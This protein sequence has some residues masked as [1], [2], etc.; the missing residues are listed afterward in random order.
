M[1]SFNLLAISIRF[2]LPWLL[3]LIIPLVGLMLWPYFRLPKQ[4]RRT[5][6]RVISL[7]I[8]SLILVL[9]VC[10]VSG[11]SLHSTE[12]VAKNDV[13]LLVDLS[14]S[15]K[16]SKE[17]MDEFIRT[18]LNKRENNYRVGIVTFANGS[19]YASQIRADSDR[20]YT[21]YLHN[22]DV[23]LGNATNI[24]EALLFAKSALSNP[25]N[26]RIIILSD[27]V[28]TDGNALAVV[29]S[30]ADGGTRVDAA[31]FSFEGRASE[32]LI[33]SVDVPQR[34]S[35]GDTLQ[36][37]VRV[38]SGSAREAK[39]KLFDN[40]ECVSE[41][42][43]QLSGGEDQ[44]VFEYSLLTPNL[45]EFRVEIAAQGDVLEENN[46]YYAYVNIETYTN[47]LVVDGTGNESALISELLDDTYDITTT[48]PAD[49]PMTITELSI[50]GEVIFMNVAN[51][52]LP[53]G[54][55]EILT[56]YVEV[57]GGGFFTVGGDKAYVQEDMKGTKYEQLLPVNVNTDKMSLGLLLIIDCSS[58]MNEYAADTNTQRIELAKQAAIASL[59]AL[60]PTDYVGVIGFNSGI[61]NETAIS[62]RDMGQKETIIRQINSLQTARGTYYQQAISY[63]RSLIT[64]FDKADLKHIIF[65]A[66]GNANDTDAQMA[67]VKESLKQMAKQG[68]TVST[69][70]L[71]P[72]F[73]TKNLEDFAEIGGGEFYNVAQE[74]KLRQIM[75]N[76]TA[77]VA[78]QRYNQVSFTPVI[79]NR[80]PAVA[81]IDELPE[82]DGFY[83]TRLKDGAT[84][85]LTYKSNPIYAEWE[86]GK[87]RVGSFM[88]DLNGHWSSSF[89]EE[90]SSGLKFI[91]NV[92]GRLFPK[93]QNDAYDA[94]RAE[95]VQDNF[96]TRVSITTAAVANT[97][98]VRVIAPD[99]T[100]KPILLE[101]LSDRAFAGTFNTDQRGIY[102]VI[103]D[104]GTDIFTKY[105]TFSYSAEHYVF[106][107]ETEAFAFME[108]L[109]KNGNG[110]ML[111]SAENVF[112][113]QN[114]VFESDYD[115]HLPLI[116]TCTTLFLIDIIVRKFK[117]KWPKEIAEER[118][119][120][121]GNNRIN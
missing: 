85:V 79:D 71:G 47:V 52:D 91:L 25:A 43:V 87:G 19:V 16:S 27:G 9:L 96:T 104:N 102:T 108:S 41:M 80:T 40:E 81:G 66:D 30:L 42:D 111:F 110:K 68:V 89:F 20:V 88:S 121:M 95:F 86:Y 101:K 106:Y 35:L 115:L 116:I 103:I 51:S 12:V 32:V 90:N 59:D 60:D 29:K 107:D 10:M 74:S 67:A 65:L 17:D 84:M 120:K 1:N 105:T 94:V 14:D 36:I 73:S 64:S 97:L 21:D 11:I 23:P 3:F 119:N 49:L 8:H 22:T 57:Y 72:D 53:A 24:A 112:G 55:D 2:A 26:G 44:F 113:V 93:T 76:E 92:V 100:S 56:E 39:L 78:G 34:A 5:R 114:E 6:N 31:F 18:A 15:N 45:H 83:G 28:Q 58:S 99:G 46:V 75:V 70:A 69:I 38:R 13:I 109:A 54:F 7:A 37:P 63:A 117:I 50:Y 82:L 118:R 98:S 61:V 77:R 4:I 62:M 33:S 48:T